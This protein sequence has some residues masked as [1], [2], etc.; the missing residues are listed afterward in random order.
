MAD[1]VIVTVGDHFEDRSE[2]FMQLVTTTVATGTWSQNSGKGTIDF[3]VQTLSCTVR[4]TRGVHR[5]FEH[6]LRCL[7]AGRKSCQ[8]MLESAG[9]PPITEFLA[10]L[11]RRP[12]P[13][14]LH[15]PTMIVQFRRTL[16]GPRRNIPAHSAAIRKVVERLKQKVDAK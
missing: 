2:D 16:F 14:S 10:N 12:S 3:S 9:G 4:Q 7:R 11:S 5:K 1:L 6:S 8:A 13:F 15:L